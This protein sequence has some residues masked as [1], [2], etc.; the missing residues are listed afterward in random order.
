MTPLNPSKQDE[1][2]DKLGSFLLGLGLPGVSVGLPVGP[3]VGA[4]KHAIC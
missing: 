3:A 1:L 4:R 2:M